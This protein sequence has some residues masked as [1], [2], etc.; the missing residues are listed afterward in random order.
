[1]TEAALQAVLRRDRVVVASALAVVI[2]LAWGYVLWLATDRTM[3]GMDTNGYRAIPA[4]MGL[5]I[6]DTVP[7]VPIEFVYV[8]LMWV[9]MM[10]GMM[11]PS[12][13]PMILIY[14]RVGRQAAALG[15]P[16]APSIWFVGGY[17]L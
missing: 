10:V 3:G 16:F 17:L 7:W 11:T 14:A 2:A 15:K 8:W 1:M 9:V 13:A 5:M 6:L 12:V 4:G